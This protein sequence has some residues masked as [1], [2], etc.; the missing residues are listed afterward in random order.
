[1]TKWEYHFEDGGLLEIQ[2][3]IELLGKTGWELIVIVRRGAD[4]FTAILKRPG[5]EVPCAEDMEP[6]HLVIPISKNLLDGQNT[7]AV[8]AILQEAATEAIATTKIPVVTGV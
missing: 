3:A 5:P 1:M 8:R 2:W 4:E 7:D 6:F